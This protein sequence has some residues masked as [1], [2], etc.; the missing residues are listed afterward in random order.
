MR[1]IF[2]F[3]GSVVVSNLMILSL[4]C[5]WGDSLSDEIEAAISVR[6]PSETG[7]WWQSLGPRAPQVILSM[8]SQTDSIYR[9]VRLIDALA[10][11]DNAR[12]T[13]WMKQA[14]DQNSNSAIQAAA[15]HSLI[16]SQG[17]KEKDFITHVLNSKDVQLRVTALKALSELSEVNDP[18]ASQLVDQFLGKENVTWAVDKVKKHKMRFNQ[19]NARNQRTQ[20]NN[21]GSPETVVKPGRLNY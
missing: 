6:H 19:G 3:L 2:Y 18:Q 7:S 1:R 21:V 10:W 17:M 5:A 14:V 12:A 4:N 8:V 15:V 11:Y 20:P 9:K 16:K 13:Q